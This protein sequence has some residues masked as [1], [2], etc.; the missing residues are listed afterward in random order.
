MEKCWQKHRIFMQKLGALTSIVNVFAA[1]NSTMEG[2]FN[3]N[4]VTLGIANAGDGIRVLAQESSDIKIEISGNT[5][6]GITQD[7]GINAFSRAGDGRLDAVI[8]GNNVMVGANAN[9]NIRVGAGASG[10]TF[11]NK[12]CTWVKNN[13]VSLNGFS[14]WEGRVVNAHELLLQG[15]GGSM[16]ANWNNNGNL[17]VSP[18]SIINPLVSGAGLISYNQTCNAPGNPPISF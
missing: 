13:T 12:T 8:S 15:T 17:P 5:V 6:S 7:N 14:Q 9:S 1:G 2:R 4:T 10:S 3:N 16:Q 11:T 18:P